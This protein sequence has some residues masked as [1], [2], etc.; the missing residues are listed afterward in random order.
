VKGP[1]RH[2]QPAS[3]GPIGQLIGGQTDHAASGEHC[4]GGGT[5]IEESAVLDEV[6]GC[7][8]RRARRGELTGAPTWTGAGEL[9]E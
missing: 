3:H 2:A 1:D 9:V 6:V 5:A 4:G 8:G 7:Q